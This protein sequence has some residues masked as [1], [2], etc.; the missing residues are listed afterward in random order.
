[1]NH[2]GARLAWE[3]F[4][5]EKPVPALIRYIEDRDIWKW[6]FAES[7]AFLAALE[8]EPRDLL[9]WAEIAAFSPEQEAAFM[10]RGGAMDEKY[11]KLCAD[12][13]DGAHAIVFNGVQGLM[14]NCPGMFHSQVGDI[15]ARESGTFALMWNANEQ[16][17]KI[18]MRSR[19]GFDCIPLAE[20]L[21]G[22]G[23]AQA[24]GCKM[25]HARLAELLS[26]DFRAD[27]LAQ[28]AE[29]TSPALVRNAQGQLVRAIHQK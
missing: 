28:Y 5:P 21:G 18:G 13:A 22:G 14:V 12:I 24:C 11:Q 27:P 23:H 1:M 10:A 17:V 7:A 25:P 4:H 16:G 15:L 26:G 9:R 8:M 20:S 19:T 3:F 29:I 6:E 2:S